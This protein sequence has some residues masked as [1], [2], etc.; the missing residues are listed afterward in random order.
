MGWNWNWKEIVRRSISYQPS[1]RTVEDL[2]WRMRKRRILI[3]YRLL[4]IFV[5]IIILACLAFFL[6]VSQSILV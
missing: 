5:L 6:L 3:R 1:D 4:Y 2:R